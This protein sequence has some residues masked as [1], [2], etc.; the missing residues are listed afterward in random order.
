M[1]DIGSDRPY[2]ERPLTAEG[3]VME[4]EQRLAELTRTL[5]DLEMAV[6]RILNWVQ[7]QQGRQL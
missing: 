2:R 6:N 5:F 1:G 7:E 3:R 4:V